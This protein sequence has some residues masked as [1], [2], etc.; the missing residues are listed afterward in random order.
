MPVEAMIRTGSGTLL[1]YLAKP[2]SDFTSRALH[3]G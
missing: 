3:E 2:L 1:R